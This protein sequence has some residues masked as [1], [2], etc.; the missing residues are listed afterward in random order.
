MMIIA[1]TEAVFE[2]CKEQ[3]TGKRLED[4]YEMENEKFI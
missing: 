4:Q 2:G 1:W 3:N